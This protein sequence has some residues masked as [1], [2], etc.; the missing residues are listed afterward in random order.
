[1]Y[2]AVLKMGMSQEGAIQ[3]GRSVQVW[4]HHSRSVLNL[5]LTDFYF[6]RLSGPGS[7]NPNFFTPSGESRTPGGGGGNPLSRL[8]LFAN[9]VELPSD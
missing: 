3:A 2:C 8:P 6:D 9:T 7:F 5:V 4:W 1:M